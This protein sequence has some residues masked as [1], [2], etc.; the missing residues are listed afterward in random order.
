MSVLRFFSS[1]LPKPDKTLSLVRNIFEIPLNNN[2][3]TNEQVLIPHYPKANP[4]DS[5]P[6]KLIPQMLIDT[7]NLKYEAHAKVIKTICKKLENKKL[8]FKIK[9]N[10]GILAIRSCCS[11]LFTSLDKVDPLTFG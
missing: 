7:L 10:I 8:D 1:Y 2:A 3:E 11:L 4:L 9:I 6:K 5:F